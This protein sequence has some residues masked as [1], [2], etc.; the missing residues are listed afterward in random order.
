M[1]TCRKRSNS[2]APGKSSSSQSKRASS[3][4]EVPQVPLIPNQHRKSLHSPR[5]IQVRGGTQS[6]SK[7]IQERILNH[8]KTEG[9]RPQKR[10]HLAKQL[11]M[12]D[13]EQYALFK[14]ALR[15]LMEAG[16]VMY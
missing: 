12:A 3:R 7:Q 2:S 13:D 16:R 15:E 5:P 14:D 9:Y 4:A 8:L 6:M 11:Q 10:R 1:L